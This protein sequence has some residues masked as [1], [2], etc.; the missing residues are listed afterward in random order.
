MK[1]YFG[2]PVS[3]SKRIS[4]TSELVTVVRLSFSG[5][6]GG[7]TK[8]Y[9][10]SKVDDTNEVFYKLTTFS[11]ETVEVN[12]SFIVEMYEKI[13]VKRVTDI[14]AWRNYH[15][16]NC[17]SSIRTEYFEIGQFD[18]FVSMQEIDFEKHL[19]ISSIDVE[20]KA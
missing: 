19:T 1:H 5:R 13:L 15:K 9:H 17:S 6:M 12:R 4:L 11:G 7:L 16:K 10:C 18:S 14:T 20:D 3:P 2:S 8:V